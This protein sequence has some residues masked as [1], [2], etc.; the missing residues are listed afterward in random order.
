MG[1]S[2]NVQWGAMDAHGATG[3]ILLFWDFRVLEL[4]DMV[5]GLFSISCHFRNC[6]D[7]FEWTFL[8]VYG[9]VLNC[10]RES[11]WEEL[12]VVQGL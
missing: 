2:R 7:S 3:G 12:G 10:N 8:G 1:A 9:P 5:I 11:F 4:V 6:E